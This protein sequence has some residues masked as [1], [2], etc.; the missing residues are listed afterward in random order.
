ME[1]KMDFLDII[2][3][4]NDLHKRIK[5]FC[6]IEIYPELQKPIDADGSM[7]WNIIGKAFGRD[8]SGGEFV[9]LNDNSIGFNSSEGETGRIAENINELFELL[10]NC[11]CWMDY[12]FIDLYKDDE[13]LKKYL[14][15]M[16]FDNENSFNEYNRNE[17]VYKDIQMELLEKMQ[18]KKYDNINEL[19]K[20]FYETSNRAPQYIYTFTEKNGSKNVSE[21][22]IIS[23]PLYPHVKK[24]MGLF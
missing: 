6:D 17:Y 10:I 11:S 8:G 24:R 16:E 4:D 23:R 14:Q 2:R 1:I 3:K 5:I 12:L 7:V 19:L 21:G 13:I 18:I 15:K 20:R 22:S 9:L